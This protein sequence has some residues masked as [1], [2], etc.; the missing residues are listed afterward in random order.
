M[1][2]EPKFAG[3]AWSMFLLPD[4]TATT[5]RDGGDWDDKRFSSL[6]VK[7]D[8][9]AP[10]LESGREGYLLTKDDHSYQCVSARKVADATYSLKLSALHF[11]SQIKLGRDPKASRYPCLHPGADRLPPLL[12]VEVKANAGAQR[13]TLQQAF[14]GAWNVYQQLVLRVLAAGSGPSAT[15]AAATTS[16]ATAVIPPNATSATTTSVTSTSVTTAAAA[17]TVS[18]TVGRIKHYCLGILDDTL[19]IWEYTPVPDP[20]RVSKSLRIRARLLCKGSVHDQDWFVRI[21]CPWR[22]YIAKES[23]VNHAVSLLPDIEHYTTRSDPRPFDHDRRFILCPREFT[24]PEAIAGDS[25]SLS[26]RMTAR[27]WQEWVQIQSWRFR[28]GYKLPATTKKQKR[29]SQASSQAESS[30]QDSSSLASGVPEASGLE[31]VLGQQPVIVGDDLAA[32][33]S[34]TFDTTTKETPEI[35]ST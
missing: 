29:S 21:Y 6:S 16:A 9:Q 5:G 14:Y 30:T 25:L 19:E 15:T 2:T 8:G 20:A 22:R 26:N 23:I 17:S 28:E 1:G 32:T 4:S 34:V 11:A 13:Q 35:S 12:S 31:A 3:S 7:R 24:I 10:I 18:T 33:L 27:F